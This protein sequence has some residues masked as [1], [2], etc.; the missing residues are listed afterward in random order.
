M[1]LSAPAAPAPVRS[2]V[3]TL[4]ERVA[5]LLPARNGV[6]WTVEPYRAWW[7][8]RPAARLSQALPG[9][10][11]GL[12]VVPRTWRTDVAWQL[13]DREPDEPDVRLDQLTPERV[14]REIM[15][16]VLPVLDDEAA[17]RAR[18][19]RQ[20]GGRLEALHEIGW[21]IRERGLAT[22]NYVGPHANSS[23]LAWGTPTG[24]RY[25]VT[26]HG[27]N[28]AGDVSVT[29]PVRAV[30]EVLPGFLALPSGAPRRKLRH[31]PGGLS[32]RLA[33][34]LVQFTAVDLLDGGG[35]A[36]GCV[37][38]AYG[39]VAPAADPVA[40]VRDTSPVSVELHGVGIDLLLSLADELTR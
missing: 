39:F 34:H 21:A 6:P 19:G 38:G 4:P 27:T 2:A 25:A 18:P 15:R 40:R 22:R 5:A 9:A 31:I 7:S 30:E 36:I 1:N 26:L 8:T 16:L 32:R 20:V 28:P 11:R 23:V 24:L 35:L 3:P 13:P 17:S 10:E 14:A 33:S 37:T 12:I 29:G